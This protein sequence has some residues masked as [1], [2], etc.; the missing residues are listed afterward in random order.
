MKG[1]NGGMKWNDLDHGLKT[2]VQI[3]VMACGLEMGLTT[4]GANLVYAKLCALICFVV[5]DPTI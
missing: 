5:K 2:L 3:S 4:F 1:C